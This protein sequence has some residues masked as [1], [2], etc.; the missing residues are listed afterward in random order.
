MS[1]ILRLTLHRK[2]FNE[3]A[4][5]IKKEEYRE[6]KP[7]WDRRIGDKMFDE[8]YFRNGCSNDRPFMRVECKGIRKESNNYVILLGKII[9]I[10]NYERNHNHQ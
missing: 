2:W 7:Y 6:I 3:I 4:S 5:G 8:I 1:K 10:Q 9:E